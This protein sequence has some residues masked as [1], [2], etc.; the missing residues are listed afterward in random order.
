MIMMTRWS[1]VAQGSARL[2]ATTAAPT[3]W[4]TGAHQPSRMT[5]RG[6]GRAPSSRLSWYSHRLWMRMAITETG[7]AIS[8]QATRECSV[9][10]RHCRRQVWSDHKGV[11]PG[12]AAGLRLAFA[13]GM[14][15][16]SESAARFAVDS[17][18]FGCTRLKMSARVSRF[19]RDR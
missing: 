6:P 3:A 19:E 12:H 5:L 13:I 8:G 17:G 1:G 4:A 2:A 14:K 15:F 18:R 16:A 10:P 9:T 11:R 7:V